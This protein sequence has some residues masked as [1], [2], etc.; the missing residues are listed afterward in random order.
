MRPLD[1][2][3]PAADHFRNRGGDCGHVV[4][5]I[6]YSKNSLPI[7]CR[8]LR[9]ENEGIDNIANVRDRAKLTPLAINGDGLVLQ[10]ESN[11][12]IHE[13]EVRTTNI[14][15]RSIDVRETHG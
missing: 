14:R 11:K 12:E 9:S 6:R 10:T 2:L 15:A 13:A 5:A 7:Y 3:Y 1:V 8:R 4:L